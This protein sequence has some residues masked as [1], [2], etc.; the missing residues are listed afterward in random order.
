MGGCCTTGVGFPG[1]ILCGTTIH[2]MS[3]M[4]ITTE[5]QVE[6]AFI[7]IRKFQTPWE[8]QEKFF[9]NYKIINF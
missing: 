7:F 9:L 4:N 1:N 3:I 8:L 2:R 5:L 6:I